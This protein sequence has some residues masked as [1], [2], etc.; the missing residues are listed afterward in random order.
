MM[1]LPDWG[2]TY[3]INVS[4]DVLKEYRGA[5][6]SVLPE[7][8]ELEVQWRGKAEHK[9]LTEVIAVIENDTNPPKLIRLKDYLGKEDL[10]MPPTNE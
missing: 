3:I 2:K 7:L 9:K 10:K 8:K 6:K 4:L 5:A 1:K